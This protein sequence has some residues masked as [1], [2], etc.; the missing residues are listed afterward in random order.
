MQE[1]KHTNTERLDALAQEV[2]KYPHRSHDWLDKIATQRY[3]ANK[4]TTK[5]RQINMGAIGCAYT[6]CGR[7]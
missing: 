4:L 2:Y 6:V 5:K 1:L 3:G 7:H